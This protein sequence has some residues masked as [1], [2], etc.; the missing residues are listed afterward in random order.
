MTHR[1]YRYLA[2]VAHYQAPSPCR[3]RMMVGAVR[4]LGIQ[5]VS[6]PL[7]RAAAVGGPLTGR[8]WW[9]NPRT[10]AQSRASHA[11]IVQEGPQ[12]VLH[13]VLTLHSPPTCQQGGAPAQLREAVRPQ[14]CGHAPLQGRQRAEGQALEEAGRTR[15]RMG[16]SCALA[17]QREP[18]LPRIL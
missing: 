18:L 7:L 15:E 11:P 1:N 14:G 17:L 5:R 9:L 3:V 2:G 12:Q 10:V 6:G 13:K 8:S 4:V 16:A